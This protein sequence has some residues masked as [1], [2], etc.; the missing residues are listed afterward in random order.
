MQKT[1]KL[2]DSVGNEIGSTYPK[3]AKGL[4][5]SGRAHMISDD[6][7][8]MLSMPREDILEDKGGKCDK[9]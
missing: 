2:I 6:T 9:F 1:I 7:I 4:I 8:C 5:K 3:R